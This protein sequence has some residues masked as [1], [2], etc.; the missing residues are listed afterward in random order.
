MK[1][2]TKSVT[3]T[4]GDKDYTKSYDRV[5]FETVDDIMAIFQDVDK[6]KKFIET[7]NYGTDLKIRAQ[8]RADILNE[9]QGPD[10][11]IEK[12]A[13]EMVKA[14][15]AVGKVITLEAALAKV[16]EMLGED[17]EAA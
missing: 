16:R 17:V 7:A 13:K 15:A 10:K 2:E 9:N 12:M 1:T 5:S 14:R 3:V 6:T 8:I 11:A 4:I